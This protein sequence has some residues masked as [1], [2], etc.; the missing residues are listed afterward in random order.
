MALPAPSPSFSD[1]AGAG[2]NICHNWA[3][4]N[5]QGARFRINVVAETT[6]I[7]EATLRAWERRYQVPKPART[8][9]GY[10]LYS[11]DDVA[12]VKRLRALCEAGVSPAD[13]AKEIL[14]GQRERPAAKPS[15]R[16]P[17]AP[18]PRPA[19]AEGDLKI[20]EVVSP[21]HTNTAGVLSLSRAVSLMERAATVVASRSAR[22]PAIVVSCGSVNLAVRVGSGQ[23]LEAAARIV[24]SRTGSISVDVELS[25]ENVETGKRGY[26]TRAVFVLVAQETTS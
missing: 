18:A 15:R 5:D 25:V 22:S 9:S 20:M 10:R 21:E 14:L 6:G 19:S 8:P 13:A 16:E 4:M 12:Q 1:Q 17:P 3:W 7:P 26:V 2:A 11:Q 23:L 24:G